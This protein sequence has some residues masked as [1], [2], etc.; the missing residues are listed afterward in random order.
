MEAQGCA[1]LLQTAG[2][3]EARRSLETGKVTERQVEDVVSAGIECGAD[4]YCAANFGLPPGVC[5][6]LVSF[7][8]GPLVSAAFAAIEEVGE[9]VGFGREAQAQRDYESM[10]QTD[11]IRDAAEEQLRQVDQLA[12]ESFALLATELARAGGV[13]SGTIAAR[14][15][16]LGVS[17]G[18]DGT[19][20]AFDRA[21]DAEFDRLCNIP[22]TPPPYKSRCYDLRVDWKKREGFLRQAYAAGAQAATDLYADWAL[23]L[24]AAATLVAGE[25]AAARARA[26][27]ERLM[28]EQRFAASRTRYAAALET[29]VAHERK[30]D[31]TN[32]GIAAGGALALAAVF[33]L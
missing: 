6:G 20:T 25:I 31:L 27:A 4:A 19:S 24:Q 22:A 14:L 26:E 15:T 5:S 3:R 32:A 33:F 10:V 30:N 17:T 16:E 2:E 12:A 21:F 29:H 11:R 1:E 7:V 28:T 8:A 9:F 13:P 23:R 18:F